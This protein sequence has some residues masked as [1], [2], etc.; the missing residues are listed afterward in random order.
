MTNA[1][2]GAL[3]VVLGMDTAQF[4]NDAA[5]AKAK[6]KALGSA[7]QTG[8]TVAAAA[9]TAAAGAIGYAMTSSI[10]Q[11]DEM[12]KAA[13]K[14]G[15]PIEE[16]SRLKYAADLSGVSFEQ[17][18]ATL[19]KTSK[20]MN[21]AK[22]GSVGAVDTFNALGVAF[23]DADGTL[24][25][26]SDVM[27][28][29]AD[30][31]AV[32]PDGAEKTALAMELMGKSGA[33]MIPMLNGGAEALAALMGEADAFGQV[34]TAEMGANAE[35]FNDNISRLQG[36]LGAMAAALAAGAL[37]YLAEFSG[38][39]VELA[40]Y[41]RSLSPEV[42]SFVAVAGAL[43]VALTA[44][45]V[46]LGMAVIAIGAIGAP[47]LA[48]VAGVT[49]LAAAGAYLY[50]HWDQIREQFPVVATVIDTAIQVIKLSLSGILENAR[51][52]AT[53]IVQLLS[54]D[55]SGAWQSA[56]ELV[57]NFWSTLGSI[58][59]AILPGFTEGL[60]SLAQIALQ[61]AS[62]I[63]AA[64]AALPGKMLE[65]G[66]QIIDGLWQGIQ[67]KWAE[68]KDG[69]TG[70]ASGIKDSFTGF[71]DINSPSRVMAEVGTDIMAGLNEG[72]AGGTGSVVAS[73]Q[74]AAQGINGALGGIQ[75]FGTS[76]SGSIDSAFSS[77]GSGLA[78]VIKGTKSWKDLLS[79]V[80]SQLA[81][82]AL[83]SMFGGMSGGGGGVGGFF[84]SLLGGLFGFANGGQFQVGGAG[85]VDSQLVAFKASPNETV[86]I[87]KPGQGRGGTNVYAPVID[88]RGA[89]QAAIARLQ[90]QMDEQ[91]RNFGK[92]VDARN[93]VRE[94]RGTRG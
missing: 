3:R 81:S 32:M 48:A 37:P 4:E 79:E 38:Y 89:D 14:V 83:Q 27:K 30:K 29:V 13:A 49:A 46:P 67:G 2:I 72:L 58:A 61:V 43:T 9:A 71:F 16:L 94:K 92:M 22:N 63:A 6:A 21:E 44:V 34:F 23:A 57:H 85:G 74:T 50:T 25:P 75:D 65:I 8:L 12:S 52:M 91:Y 93:G 17:L 15:V 88:A 39:L 86:S 40:G 53:G 10:N 70:I 45:L 47:V 51:L 60:R 76:I 78:E 62:D 66:G 90:R 26:V 42:Q 64:F 1:V 84:T 59:D 69:V 5:A 54:G 73:A 24:R 33:G 31:F 87:T 7:L 68:L 35:A 80:L 77:L 20:V 19:A 28:D 55:F 11:A 36:A 56:Q 41:F 18:Q 82:S